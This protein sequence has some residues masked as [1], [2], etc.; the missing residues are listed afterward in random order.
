M[1]NNWSRSYRRWRGPTMANNWSQSYRRWRGPTMANNRLRLSLSLAA[2]SYHD[3]ELLRIPGPPIP[4]FVCRHNKIGLQPP[5]PPNSIHPK[6]PQLHSHHSAPR[7][8]ISRR[9]THHAPPHRA[10]PYAALRPTRG[11]TPCH[12]MPRPTTTRHNMSR[13]VTPRHALAKKCHSTTCPVMRVRG[14]VRL[15]V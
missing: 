9:A 1:A 11:D 12:P 10:M 7:P 15:S 6:S 14:S 8:R 13:D 4:G 5:K 2:R 3:K